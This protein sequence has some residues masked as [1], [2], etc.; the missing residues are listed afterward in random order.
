MEASGILHYFNSGGMSG[1]LYCEK[2]VLILVEFFFFFVS[3]EITLCLYQAS[4]SC[5]FI[6][7]LIKVRL[8]VIPDVVGCWDGIC[9][10]R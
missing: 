3:T 6:P 4:S 5:L 10:R 8:I 1:V 2:G 9:I 7:T